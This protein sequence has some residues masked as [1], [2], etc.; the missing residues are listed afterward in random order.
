MPKFKFTATLKN[1]DKLEKIE[2]SGENLDMTWDE[3]FTKVEK[4]GDETLFHEDNLIELHITRD[5]EPV[6]V[7]EKF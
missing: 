1:A 2:G 6:I 3:I 7:K 5:T 4:L